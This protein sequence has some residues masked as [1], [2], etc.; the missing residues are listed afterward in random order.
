[1][2]VTGYSRSQIKRL[3]QQFVKT[4]EIKVKT[5][6]RNGF[7][8]RYTQSDIRLLAEMDERHQQP[9]GGR[10]QKALRTRLS[11]VWTRYDKFI[12]L[13]NPKQYLK[14][15]ITPEQLN[16]FSKK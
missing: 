14:P 7:T 4:S 13:T 1:M 12:S 2:K 3:I 5:A 11:T 16:A 9:N 6:R 8:N 15:D 10:D